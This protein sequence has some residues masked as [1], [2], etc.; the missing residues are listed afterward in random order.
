MADNIKI[1]GQI[2]DTSI[3]TRYSTQDEQLL[4]PILQKDTF[5]QID[6]Y[7]EYFVFDLGGSV[8]NS[9]Y[10]YKSYKLPPNTGYSQSLLPNIEIDPI[11]DIENLGYQS[12]DVTSRYNFFRKVSGQPFDNQLFI[13]QIS[14]D[15]TEIR[16][17]STILSDE[18]LL[19]IVTDFAGK[20]ESVPY[21]YYV[22]L[23]FGN[24][25]HSQID[26][27]TVTK[28]IETCG[29][30]SPPSKSFAALLGLTLIMLIVCFKM[31]LGVTGLPS[32]QTVKRYPG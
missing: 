30:S 3:V 32:G 17:N 24:N 4:L 28:L 22:I 8:L 7:I 26:T 2:T 15:R 10:N 21:Y 14:T 1:V 12:G 20:Q 11:Q 6:D 19:A 31:H 23:N 13:Q 16:V 5:G 9:D 25:N 18:Q 27:K 29:H